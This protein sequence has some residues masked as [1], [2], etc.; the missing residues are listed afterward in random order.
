MLALQVITIF[1]NVFKQIGLD[2]F[3]FPYRVVATAPGCGV[4]ECV[5]HAKSR[6]QLGRQTDIGMYEYFINKYGGDETTKE[7]QVMYKY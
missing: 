3:L 4:I 7:F 5:P 1:K 2:V 6:D